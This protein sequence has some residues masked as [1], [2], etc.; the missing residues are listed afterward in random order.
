MRRKLSDYFARWLLITFE[1][2]WVPGEVLEDW[3]KVNV[4]S[5]LKE[6]LSLVFPPREV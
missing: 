1:S 3:K 6:K 4:N 5:V 2:L